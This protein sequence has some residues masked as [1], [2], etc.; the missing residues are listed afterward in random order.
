MDHLGGRKKQRNLI[1]NVRRYRYAAFEKLCKLTFKLHN[2]QGAKLR[3]NSTHVFFM[4]RTPVWIAPP[5]HLASHLCGGGG[6]GG[7]GKGGNPGEDTGKKP[8]GGGGRGP[9]AKM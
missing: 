1:Q 4:T 8:V 6:G 5:I 2:D 3:K 7:G 9:G